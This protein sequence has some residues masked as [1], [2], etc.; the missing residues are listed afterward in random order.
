MNEEMHTKPY[1]DDPERQGLR[2]KN[3]RSHTAPVNSTPNPPLRDAE[4]RSLFAQR[5]ATTHLGH[6]HNQHRHGIQDHE[7]VET[8]QF[9]LAS[10]MMLDESPTRA[11]VSPTIR[12][13]CL[14]HQKY[15]ETKFQSLGIRQCGR[16]HRQHVMHYRS[17]PRAK[18]S[19][20]PAG[21]TTSRR[22]AS[23][24]DGQTR[25]EIG[26]LVNVN[27]HRLQQ[28]AAIISKRYKA[29]RVKCEDRLFSR[30]YLV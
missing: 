22:P 18:L 15:N 2:C 6:G 28:D 9:N 3:G 20:G 16:H 21:E 11:A 5:P 26:L 4:P 25:E 13:K 19:S 12:S 29:W 23:R 14:C 17:W 27:D 8:P 10:N 1:V 30:V 7:K 24:P